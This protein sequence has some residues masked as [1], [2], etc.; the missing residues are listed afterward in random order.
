MQV[1]I[2]TDTHMG[3]RQDNQHFHKFFIQFFNDQ[4]F[5]LLKE[6]GIKTVFHL[7]D[8]FERRTYINFVT[9]NMFNQT[10]VKGVEDNDLDVFGIIGN[11]DTTY[12]NSNH[13]NSIKELIGNTHSRIKVWWDAPH[14][15]TFGGKTFLFMPWMNANN[16]VESMDA[17]DQTEASIILGHFDIH[18]FAMNMGHVQREKGFKP[19]E[20]KRFPMVL[21]GHYHQ[22]QDQDNIHYLGAPYE[23]NWG[24]FNQPKGF[25]ILDTDTMELEF[26]QNQNKMFYKVIY[27]DRDKFGPGEILKED[28]SHCTDKYVKVIIS[29]KNNPHMF[30]LYMDKLYKSNPANIQVVEDH[31][32]LN[33]LNEDDLIAQT[34]DTLTIMRKYVTNLDLATGKE[35]VETLLI[36]L[37]NEA[38][39]L[40]IE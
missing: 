11:H 31:Q 24:D 14:E 35:Q 29:G 20:F 1:A 21:T 19:E 38:I 13:I 27:D 36:D 10:F 12:R 33:T 32:N 4:F 16:Y 2:I 3:I 25:H 37:Y 18:G 28:F 22:K 5:P 40:D 30:D 6:R 26:I 39:N 15:L 8:W 9:L 34:E 7:G 23:M 17:L